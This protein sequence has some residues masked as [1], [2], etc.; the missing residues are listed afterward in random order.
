MWGMNLTRCFRLYRMREEGE[1]AEGTYPVHAEGVQGRF[2]HPRD[3]PGYGG[4]GTHL[5][6]PV[7]DP[8]REDGGGEGGQGRETGQHDPRE[9]TGDPRGPATG[10]GTSE[11]EATRIG[12]SGQDSRGDPVDVRP[13]V[14]GVE[15]GK[16]AQER[17]RQR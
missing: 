10:E 11:P 4:S 1:D 13:L 6:H 7:S 15:E 17:I 16:R 12:A 3:F 14:G 2:L 5:L 9:G 8:G